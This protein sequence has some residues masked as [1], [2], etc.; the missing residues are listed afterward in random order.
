MLQTR[1]SRSNEWMYENLNFL[2]A[3]TNRALAT[4]FGYI[5]FASLALLTEG[6]CSA[7]T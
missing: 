5:F 2:S 7:C 3:R 4:Y 6:S 1:K